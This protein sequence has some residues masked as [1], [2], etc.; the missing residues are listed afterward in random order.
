MSG[1]RLAV[2]I[3]ARWYGR[4][5]IAVLRPLAALYWTVIALRRRAYRRGWLAV[6]R[7]S[8]P[9]LVI[10]NLSVGG[11]GKT[12]LV[13][14]VIERARA[15]GLRPGV[16]S[17]GY[18]GESAEYPVVVTAD[19]TPA[20]AGDEPV[21]IARRTGVPVVVAPDRVA[22]A[23]R[24]IAEADVDVIIADD[25]LQHYR[26]ARDAE[27]AVI[28]ARRGYG[29]G[30][31]LPAGPLREPIS[32][33]RTVDLECVQGEAR[34]FWLD[35]GA[36][37]ALA[38]GALRPLAEFAA[39]PVHAIAGIG[40][41]ARFFDMLTEAGLDVMPHAAPDHHR[42]RPADL[43]FGDAYPILMTEKDAVKCTGFASSAALWSV[44][45][46]TC[47]APACAAAID[48][49]LQRITGKESP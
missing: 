36:A 23:H 33:L 5:P 40:E 31:L 38:D 42:Y 29:N 21:L 15:L 46:E 26:L 32:R 14:A 16:V 25:G 35:A 13:L 17:R 19:T 37:R 49:L 48:A 12:P 27:I 18:G 1:S 24:L 3:Q 43:A 7:V 6:E 4:R 11:S 10:G 28:D 2:A 47:L 8:R 20:V 39:T 9:V 41:P 30:A 34:D 22:A 45:V 44:P